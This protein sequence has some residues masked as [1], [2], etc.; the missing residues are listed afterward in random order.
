MTIPDVVSVGVSGA[1]LYTDVAVLSVTAAGDI[2][3]NE[4]NAL[5]LVV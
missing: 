2:Y 5:T 4:A 3:I 1:E